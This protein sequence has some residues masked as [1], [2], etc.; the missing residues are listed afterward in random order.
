MHLYLFFFYAGT[1]M[2]DVLTTL[3]DYSRELGQGGARDATA[4]I[5]HSN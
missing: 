5:D 2:F 1:K 3:M 4:R